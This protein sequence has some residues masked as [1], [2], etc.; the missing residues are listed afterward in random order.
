MAGILAHSTECW[1]LGL[2]DGLASG[3]VGRDIGALSH[4]SSTKSWPN[5][6]D[7]LKPAS[8]IVVL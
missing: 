8:P 4:A 3:V 7:T 2:E 5:W 1:Q 6:R